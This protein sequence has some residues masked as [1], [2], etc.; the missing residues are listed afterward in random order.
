M[1][2]NRLTTL[3]RPKTLLQILLLAVLATTPALATEKAELLRY[4]VVADGHPIALWEKSAAGAS[5]AI[6][7]RQGTPRSAVYQQ[8]CL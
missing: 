4:T 5:E 3:T 7:L 8:D 6:L 1:L 2:C